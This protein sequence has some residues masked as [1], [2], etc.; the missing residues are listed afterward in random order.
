MFS[1][2]ALG[3]NHK[4]FDKSYD[5]SIKAISYLKMTN[6]LFHTHEMNSFYESFQNVAFHKNIHFCSTGALAFESAVKCAFEVIKDPN[7]TV[8][9][10]KNSFHGIN[11]WGFLT[12]RSLS[13]VTQR[14][15]NF[16]KNN[17]QLFEVDELI[18]N[19]EN[20]KVRV[21][22]V[23]IEPIQCTAG[24]IY[25]SKDN[26]FKIQTACKKNNVCFIVDEV[27]TGFGV[28]GT[29]WYSKK[30]G[31]DPDIVIFGK[32]SQI[33]GIMTNEKYAEAI[34]SKYRKLEV[35]FDGDL[36]DA[37]RSKFIIK[38]I[39]EDNL[40]ENVSKMSKLISSE[41]SGSLLNYRSSGF[42]IAFDFESKSLRDKFVG[43]AFKESLLLNPTADKTV[44]VRPNLALNEEE[45]EDFIT[46]VKFSLK[47]L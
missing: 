3:Y 20:P 32:K 11:S 40:L 2:L 45:M 33:S 41:L 43:N 8:L 26:L 15:I 36:I 46:K 16:P 30:M 25:L 4:V 17:W 27:Q 24:D 14:I 9:G 47:E 19:I 6:N 34:K 12:D 39:K 31:L 42:L 23:V 5:E 18:E 10:L 1:S 38:A 29:M 28:T 35:T 22:A 44:R 37:I 7:S 21:A 13:S